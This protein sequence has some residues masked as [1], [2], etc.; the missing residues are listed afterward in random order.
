MYRDV[1]VLGL[2][3]FL[4]AFTA[5]IV[6]SSN[7]DRLKG[8]EGNSNFSKPC[9]FVRCD[10]GE[11][12]VSRKF[13][14]KNPPCPIMHYC[15]KTPRESLKGPITCESVRCSKG[16]ICL[17]KVRRCHWDRRCTQQAARCVSDHEYYDGPTSC[18]DFHCPPDHR[19]IL[20]E[21][22]CPH[23]PCRLL[24][25]C[26]KNK[27]V[28]AWHARCRNLG[29][30]SEYECFLR[31]PPDNCSSSDHCKHTPDCTS[32]NVNEVPFSP[33]CR[34]WICPRNQECSVIVQDSCKLEHGTENCETTRVCREPH[35]SSET[36]S[37]PSTRLVPR[38]PTA[39]NNVWQ[40]KT[41]EPPTRSTV[42]EGLSLI[43]RDTTLQDEDGDEKVQMTRQ[44]I[45][46]T[47]T[48]MYPTVVP[49]METAAFPSY[50]TTVSKVDSRLAS[51]PSQTKCHCSKNTYSLPSGPIYQVPVY[52]KSPVIKNDADVEKVVHPQQPIAPSMTEWL[53]YLRLK[54]GLDA[55]KIWA[56]HAE[57]NVKYEYFKEWLESVKNSLG[58][59]KFQIWLREVRK[60]TSDNPAFQKWLLKNDAIPE[61]TKPYNEDD[62]SIRKPLVEFP[63]NTEEVQVPV[64][65]KT[66][67]SQHSKDTDNGNDPADKKSEPGITQN[68]HDDQELGQIQDQNQLTP[69]EKQ[70]RN[71][72]ISQVET[73]SNDTSLVMP[74]TDVETTT[75]RPIPKPR[76]KN[77]FD[78]N[79]ST[80]VPQLFSVDQQKPSHLS[81]KNTGHPR[82]NYGEGPWTAYHQDYYNLGPDSDIHSIKLKNDSLTESR[83]PN[84]TYRH[85][86]QSYKTDNNRSDSGYSTDLSESQLNIK[87]DSTQDNSVDFAA[88]DKN[89]GKDPREDHPINHFVQ[90]NKSNEILPS[91]NYRPGEMLIQEIYSAENDSTVGSG[92][93]S[94]VLLQNSTNNIKTGENTKA[95][96]VKIN[97]VVP[98]QNIPGNLSLVKSN[99]SSNHSELDVDSPRNGA[100]NVARNFTAQE[101]S[102]AMLL[103]HFP[104]ENQTESPEFPAPRQ[105]YKTVHQSD[106]KV[107]IAHTY[108]QNSSADVGVQTKEENL[109]KTFDLF[110]PVADQLHITSPWDAVQVLGPKKRTY[111]ALMRFPLERVNDQLQIVGYPLIVST[112]SSIDQSDIFHYN[113]GNLNSQPQPIYLTQNSEPHVPPIPWN[114]VLKYHKIPHRSPTRQNLDEVEVG[115]QEERIDLK[116][117][118]V[119][120]QQVHK[121]NAHTELHIP[122]VNSPHLNAP[123]ELQVQD[124]GRWHRLGTVQPTQYLRNK[125]K[126]IE[127]EYGGGPSIPYN[128]EATQSMV[129]MLTSGPRTMTTPNPMPSISNPKPSEVAEI[130]YDQYECE[131]QGLTPS[132]TLET[133]QKAFAAGDPY[134]PNSAN[135]DAAKYYYENGD[136]YG[137]DDGPLGYDD[138]YSEQLEINVADYGPEYYDGEIT[139]GII[140]HRT[141]DEDK[142]FSK[143]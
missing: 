96:G 140:I 33:G 101:P 142:S 79:V 27:D 53:D 19:C 80:N 43:V 25:S 24:R 38:A 113:A 138:G 40:L 131:E 85:Q 6:R 65:D 17:V 58:R 112:T 129:D 52:V 31:R 57:E 111:Y 126:N 78:P 97:D 32:T 41:P 49:P 35:A 114:L 105:D 91:K 18:A 13:W 107:P 60:L 11:N 119:S 8:G 124:L 106:H 89:F 135:Y 117:Q 2:S 3:I 28:Q 23:S 47:T 22:K 29:C 92:L 121:K 86:P 30:P 70:S 77:N 125:V 51:I 76:P 59:L 69:V 46:G 56:K 54:T 7:N 134:S 14:C 55:I 87:N 130:E 64:L 100:K 16:Y 116:N 10:Q 39:V 98:F 62:S 37:S 143:N 66:Q 45:G 90:L 26:A 88:R 34:G 139:Q 127:R 137:Y 122:L 110:A 99:Q 71:S 21:S 115:N 123:I 118:P 5:D 63:V 128:V 67:T 83:P 108:S 109:T 72:S 81:K 75:S 74:R 50:P 132:P 9:A 82:I 36:I 95:P 68:I 73:E 136:K 94:S 12:C 93:N 4:F 120:A 103:E 102:T 141:A 20:R 84:S 42:D 61:S 1:L 48:T 15:S 133:N 104:P 44:K